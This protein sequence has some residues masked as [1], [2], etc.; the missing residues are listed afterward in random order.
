[1]FI[2]YFQDPNLASKIAERLEVPQISP[3]FALRDRCDVC[4]THIKQLK[5]EAVAMVHSIQQA[6][7]ESAPPT[8]IPALVGSCNFSQVQRNNPGANFN[9]PR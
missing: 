8:N 6:Q 1:M 9:H 2:V 7:C 5:Q 3:K 4:D